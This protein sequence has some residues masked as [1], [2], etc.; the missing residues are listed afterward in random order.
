MISKSV[1]NKDMIVYWTDSEHYYIDEHNKHIAVTDNE[2]NMNI[3]M[4]NPY[5]ELPFRRTPFS[6]FFRLLG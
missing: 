2:G 3:A 1:N 4:L 6:I 5:G